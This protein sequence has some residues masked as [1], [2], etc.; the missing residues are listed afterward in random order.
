M[1][2]RAAC[3]ADEL[4]VKLRNLRWRGERDRRQK[5]I[6]PVGTFTTGATSTPVVPMDDT[7]GPSR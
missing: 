1:L 4:V 5:T 3:A 7:V 2:Q 6:V